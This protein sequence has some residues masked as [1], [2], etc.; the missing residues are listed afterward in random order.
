M[1][2]SDRASQ[3]AD[4]GE[5]SQDVDVF[6]TEVDDKD[7]QVGDDAQRRHFAMEPKPLDAVVACLRL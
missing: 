6:S 1:V 2:S 5:A 3:L 4:E 7:H